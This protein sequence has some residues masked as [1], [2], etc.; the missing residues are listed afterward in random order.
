[1]QT[2]LQALGGVLLHLGVCAGDVLHGR[3]LRKQEYMLHRA[4]IKFQPCVTFKRR[5][6]DLEH[7]IVFEIS[8]RFCCRLA[9]VEAKRN[10]C[11]HIL[12]WVLRDQHALEPLSRHGFASR[13]ELVVDFLRAEGPHIPFRELADHR[14]HVFNISTFFGNILADRVRL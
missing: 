2:H 14:V 7:I 4:P 1:M 12:C 13:L 8:Y 3:R 10:G 11:Q 6:G 9:V 5:C